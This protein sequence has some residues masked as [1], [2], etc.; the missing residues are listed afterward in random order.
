MVFLT[1]AVSAASNAAGH[2]D[3]MRFQ[4]A[5]Q[6]QGRQVGLE[7]LER[8][9]LAQRMKGEASHEDQPDP[10]IVDHLQRLPAQHPDCFEPVVRLQAEAF[11]RAG[12]SASAS[13]SGRASQP[14]ALP[15]RR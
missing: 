8:M 12:F 7:V 13:C 6:L 1:V 10:L 4:N 5:S 11:R 3:R 9:V 2:R 15:S 14:I